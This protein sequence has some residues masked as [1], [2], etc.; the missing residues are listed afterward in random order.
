MFDESRK[1]KQA[2][3]NYIRKDGKV[4]KAERTAIEN[5]SDRMLGRVL[6]DMNIVFTT[7]SNCGGELLGGPNSFE[8][9]VIVCDEAGHISIPSLCVP[10]T[11]FTKWEGLFLFGDVQQLKPS[12]SSGQFNEF[13]H[14]AKV[15]PLALLAMK[16]VQ[17]ILLNEQYRMSP[18]C[19]AFPRMEFYDG[20]G[21]KDSV[22]VKRDNAIRKAVR[23]VSIGLGVVGDNGE[24]SGYFVTN[25]ARGC[26]SQR[27]V[28]GESRQC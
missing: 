4:G 26:R 5:E 10:L 24:G 3:T 12:A 20:E 11:T 7:A 23:E 18:A 21:L 28:P 22:E 13:V 15:S 14:D 1:Y 9:T 16:G 19:S 17:P 8:P 27:D 6:A 2:V 25:V